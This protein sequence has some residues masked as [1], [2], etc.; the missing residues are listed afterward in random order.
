MLSELDQVPLPD[1]NKT[2]VGGSTIQTHLFPITAIELGEGFVI[3]SDKVVTKVSGT[4]RHDVRPAVPHNPSTPRQAT[5]TH[6]YLYE[7]CLEVAVLQAGGV[8]R[9]GVHI[10]SAGDEVQLVLL[11]TQQ[12]IILWGAG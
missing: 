4:F 3:G 2:I 11:P 5:V 7:D 8:L 10:S 6:V 1:T 12:A 9:P